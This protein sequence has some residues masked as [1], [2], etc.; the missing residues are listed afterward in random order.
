MSTSFIIEE[1]KRIVKG[2]V[3]YDSETLSSYSRDASVCQVMPHVIVRPLDSSDISTVVRFVNQYKTVYP[4]LS[5]TPRSAGTDMS[6]GPLGQSIILDINAHLQGIIGFEKKPHEKNVG[7]RVLPGTFYRDLEKAAKERGLFLPSYPASKDICT[8]GGMV[9]NNSAGEKTLIYGQTKE[10]VKEVKIIFH[11]GNEYTV[12]PLTRI[13]LQAKIHQ[14]DFEGDLYRE[15]WKTISL[16]KELIENQKPK[17][18]KNSAGYFLW[19]VWDKKNDIFDL[20]KLICG[21]QGTLG[22]V[23][24]IVFELVPIPNVTKLLTVFL[25]T[26]DLIGPLVKDILK[27]RP[28]SLESYDEETIKLAVT[29]FKDIVLGKSVDMPIINRVIYGIKLFWNFIPEFRIALSG[30]YPKLMMLI[31]CTGDD[32]KSVLQTVK[33]MEKNI[34]AGYSRQ[35]GI[36]TRVIENKDEVLKYWLIRRESYNLLRKHS[37]GKGVATFI[38]D[39]VVPPGCLPEFLPKL[40]AILKEYN[41]RYSIA[42]HA[43]SGN[44]HIFPLMDFN[45]PDH[46]NTILD[47]S[48]KVYSLVSEYK[49]SITAEHNDG[50]SRTPFLH[51]MYSEEMIHLF[52]HVKYLFDPYAIF[53]PGKKVL[54]GHLAGVSDTDYFKKH[55]I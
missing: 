17:T 55:I 27:Y 1:L 12:K 21:S 19:D 37:E 10:F 5:I 45:D 14:F 47:I 29:Y 15:I 24:E 39:V 3:L 28:L 34:L 33:D 16:H 26:L 18:S 4:D 43:G 30:G 46:A 8:V 54:Q 51:Y 40:R 22:I 6:G 31:E 13:E 35:Y 53:N 25:P 2:E 42:G 7:V 20:T 36:K 49:G 11:D 48:R 23:T 9:A 41:L 32:E 50:I 44:F 52:R 38:E